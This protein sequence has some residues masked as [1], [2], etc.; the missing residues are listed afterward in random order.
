MKKSI[1][2]FSALMAGLISASAADLPPL[3]RTRNRICASPSLQLDGN[4][5][6]ASTEGTHLASKTR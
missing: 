2:V 5:I 4:L 3:P 1:V 6:L